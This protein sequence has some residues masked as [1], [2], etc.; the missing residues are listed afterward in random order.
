MHK[1]PGISQTKP[2][3]KYLTRYTK[4]EVSEKEQNW[5]IITKIWLQK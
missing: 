5:Y 2:V 4:I 3:S 1:M